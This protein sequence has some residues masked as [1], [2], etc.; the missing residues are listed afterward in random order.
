ME[1]GNE[2]ISP[3]R[4]TEGLSNLLEDPT[5][6]EDARLYVNTSWMVNFSSI[7]DPNMPNDLKP[8]NLPGQNPE[9]HLVLSYVYVEPQFDDR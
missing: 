3:V 5:P 2:G 9:P 4:L 1:R 7:L 8:P 6:T